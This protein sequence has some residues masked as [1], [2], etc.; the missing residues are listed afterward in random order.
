MLRPSPSESSDVVIPLAPK[1][2]ACEVIHRQLLRAQ[3]MITFPKVRKTF[4]PYFDGVCH[5][6][7][8]LEYCIG[9]EMVKI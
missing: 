6:D 4:K 7:I 9:V 1:N 2:T 5:G 8:R 3:A